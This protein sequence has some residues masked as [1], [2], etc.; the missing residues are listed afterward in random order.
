MIGTVVT[1]AAGLAGGAWLGRRLAHRGVTAANALAGRQVIAYAVMLGLGGVFALLYWAHKIPL[2]PTMLVLLGEAAVWPFAQ[3]LAA[4]A[5]GVLVL[6]EW[7]GR[8]D[9]KR[10]ASMVLG[11]LA[12]ALC[13]GFLV[14]RALPLLDLLGP[15]R[16]TDGVVMQTT[17]YT[18]AP[19]TIATLLRA[20]GDTAASERQVVALA[21]TT[22]AGTTTFAE[23]RAMR[24]LGLAPQFVRGL[25]PESLAARGQAAL[26][27]VDEPILTTTI[28]H[29]VALL[30]VDAERRTITIGNPLYGRQIKS[31]ESLHGYWT[32]EAVLVGRQ[33]RRVARRRRAIAPAAGTYDG[34]A[35]RTAGPGAARR[36]T[37]P[38]AA[39]A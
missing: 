39:A 22:R 29:A 5:L 2:L 34:A 31:W 3:L 25:T 26:L 16:I 24:R 7:P 10:L 14:Y 13:N 1:A 11:S 38:R 28:R 36:S 6:L 37:G 21:G 20:R 18:C 12:L 30:A 23:V 32:G 9:R 19:A 15:P 17:S 4:A 33:G 35:P 8:R 27:H